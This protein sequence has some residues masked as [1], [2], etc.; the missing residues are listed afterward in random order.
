[1]K[2]LYWIIA[3]AVVALGVFL[4]IWLG[5][6]QRTVPKITLSY[7]ST[8]TEI[9]QSVAK[10]LD[11]EISQNSFFWLGVEPEKIEQ[12]AVISEIKKVIEAKNGKFTQV[13]IDEELKLPAEYLKEIEATQNVMLKENIP[14]IGPVLEKLEK[15]N[16]KYLFITAA[17]YSNSFTK[18]NQIHQLKEVYKINPLSVS[19]GYFA[20]TADEE[21]EATFRCSTEDKS[22][23]SNWGCALINKARGVRRKFNFKIAKP[24]SGVMDLTGEKDYMLLLR[25]K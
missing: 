1:M 11:Q 23:A 22:G 17:L 12:L 4:S 24:W 13:I 16:T 20:A 18:E 5:D 10:R 7:F 25:K 21:K 19:L 2:A 14:T 15:E 6:T 8:E 3:A 9:A